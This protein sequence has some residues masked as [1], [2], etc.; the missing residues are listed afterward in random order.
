V[1]FIGIAVG[2]TIAA[3]FVFGFIFGVGGAEDRTPYL[4]WTSS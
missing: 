1:R 4:L 3:A 2:V